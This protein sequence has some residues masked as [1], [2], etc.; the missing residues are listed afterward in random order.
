M[1]NQD[2]AR[3]FIAQF[4]AQ[5]LC[6]YYSKEGK[7]QHVEETEGI[8]KIQVS[9]FNGRRDAFADLEDDIKQMYACSADP[10][11]IWDMY[12]CELADVAK[13]I[14][15]IAASEAAVERTFSAQGTVHSKKRN[16]LIG[17]VVEAEMMIKF[18]TR[19]LRSS[20][21][22]AHKPKIMVMD[23]SYEPAALLQ[24]ED[25]EEVEELP[26][27]EIELEQEI[28]SET[29]DSVL[30]FPPVYFTRREHVEESKKRSLEFVAEYLKER[31]I[32]AGYVW[33]KEDSNSIESAVLSRKIRGLAITKET[34]YCDNQ[35]AIELSKNDLYHDR[36]KHID[37][38]Y[39]FIRECIQ[40]KL[41]SLQYI[42]TTE[43][44][45][46]IFTKGLQ[47]GLF[48]KFRNM[49]MMKE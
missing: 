20:P 11:N 41:F 36:T 17:K 5:Y 40:K 3:R 39:H 48:I 47:R 45:A 42:S 13:A 49:I 44:Q 10:L 16:R 34:L 1:A 15:T 8:L 2:A 28:P 29:A 26:A 19:A 18:N 14:I 33:S 24:S 4:G 37:L 23:D 9:Q 21:A 12:T 38:R 22:D 30:N 25:E 31:E 7:F 27:A 35:S 32:G 43:Q 46:D 6:Y